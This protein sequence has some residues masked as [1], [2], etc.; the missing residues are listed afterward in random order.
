[1]QLRL[2][3]FGPEARAV[4]RAQLVLEIAELPIDCSTLRRCVAAAEPRLKDLLTTARFAVNCSF[5]ADDAMVGADD[6]V[7]IINQVCGG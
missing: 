1:M 4:G 3:L 6:E 5:V 2:R 7:A